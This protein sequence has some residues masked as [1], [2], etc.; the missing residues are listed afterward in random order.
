MWRA[1]DVMGAEASLRLVKRLPAEAGIGGGS[2]DAAAVLRAIGGSTVEQQMS[3]GADVPVC[4]LATA[5]R[6]RGVGEGGKSCTAA[7]ARSFG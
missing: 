5:A 2:S 4:M 3:L 7:T 1:L 6:M